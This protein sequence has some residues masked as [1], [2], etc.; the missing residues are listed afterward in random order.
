ML[1]FKAKSK[2]GPG[3]FL[4]LSREN[5]NRL[6]AGQPIKVNLADM[7]GPSIIIG[8]LF[9]ET[10]KALFEHLQEIGALPADLEYKAASSGT[11]EVFRFKKEDSGFSSEDLGG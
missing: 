4:G 6:V 11:A 2:E 9:G 10:E 8:I 7:G 5:I 3:Y 1:K